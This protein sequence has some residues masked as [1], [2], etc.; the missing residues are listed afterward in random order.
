[1]KLPEDKTLRR[2]LFKPWLY[3]PRYWVS[4]GALTICTTAGSMPALLA[5]TPQE[6]S[7]RRFDIPAG[8]LGI[9]I[10]PFRLQLIG[11]YHS[12]LRRWADV[13]RLS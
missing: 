3:R 12:L 11:V 1:M 4:V 10:E 5:Q 7:P 8:P 6:Q 13:L 9:A 2:A